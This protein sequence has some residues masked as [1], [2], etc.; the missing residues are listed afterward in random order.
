MVKHLASK[1]EQIYHTDQ[2]PK[3]WQVNRLI[4]RIESSDISDYRVVCAVNDVLQQWKPLRPEYE[5]SYLSK[6]RET[7]WRLTSFLLRSILH[8]RE[9]YTPEK[10]AKEL[11][12]LGYQEA[13][14]GVYLSAIHCLI[15]VN[16]G[17]LGRTLPK[18]D[19]MHRVL[20]VDGDFRK[21]LKLVNLYVEWGDLPAY[22]HYL[23][24]R[25]STWL[26]H[27]Q[28]NPAYAQNH[29]ASEGTHQT[30]HR[31]PQA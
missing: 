29:G 28:E 13:D 2:T 12:K 19:G 17:D 5:K 1:I 15:N 8:Y 22:A 24:I 3:V 14:F 10:L 21:L 20:R 4:Q 16:K 9:Y 25:V 27:L 7:Q 30:Y 18:L 23:F 26:S 31:V 6:Y 11:Q